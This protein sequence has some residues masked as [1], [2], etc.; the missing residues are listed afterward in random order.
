MVFSK[1]GNPDSAGPSGH[2]LLESVYLPTESVRGLKDDLSGYVHNKDGVVFDSLE[3][4]FESSL[5]STGIKL[6]M[7][8]N[9]IKGLFPLHQTLPL[10]KVSYLNVIFFLMKHVEE[11]LSLDVN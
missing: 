6:E 10:N 2:Q 1:P 11:T 4:E 9:T 3:L 7:L 5:A 8:S